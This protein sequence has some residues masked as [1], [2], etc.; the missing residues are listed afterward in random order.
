M[1]SG[2]RE[3]CPYGVNDWDDWETVGAGLAPARGGGRL[4]AVIWLNRII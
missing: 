1:S 3:G 4:Q 2:S